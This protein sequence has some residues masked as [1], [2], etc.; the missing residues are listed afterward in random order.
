M[1]APP[2]PAVL[3]SPRRVPEPD[4]PG[5]PPRGGGRVA[6]MDGLRALCF[7]GV[8]AEHAGGTAFHGGYA[9]VFV[10]FALSG[11]LV[12]GLLDRIDG[13]GPRGLAGFYARRL[14]RICPLYYAALAVIAA[15]W[16]VG[17]LGWYLA[18]L[19]NFPLAYGGLTGAPTLHFW[20]LAVEFQFYMLFPPAYLLT[21][22]RHRV[23]LLLALIA[24]SKLA[25]MTLIGP[26]DG[27][28]VTWIT[29]VAAEYLLW[30]CLLGL[31]PRAGAGAVPGAIAGLGAALV[32]VWTAWVVAHDHAAG[33]GGLALGGTIDGIG[34]ALLVYGLWWSRG[35]LAAALSWRPLVY[36][37]TISYGLYVIHMPMVDLMGMA[38]RGVPGLW[39]LWPIHWALSLVPTV[40]LAAASWRWFER[41]IMRWGRRPSGGA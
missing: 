31:V 41:P 24:A 5:G 33:A 27:P 32:V 26:G 17:G 35:P 37:G 8:F 7:L 40:A 29:P 2:A 19:Q 21:P 6:Q 25:R 39:R 34:S 23:A 28:W 16:H 14:L 3:P 10:F 36:L 13:P 9:G 4:G 22:R 15:G 20:S 1:L 18:Y 38:V 12:V 30:G 11:F